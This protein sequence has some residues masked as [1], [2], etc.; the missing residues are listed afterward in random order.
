VDAG[1]KHESALVDFPE[2]RGAML[3]G[4][5]AHVGDGDAPYRIVASLSSP[6]ST[7]GTAPIHKRPLTSTSSRV[8]ILIMPQSTIAFKCDHELKEALQVFA[9]QQFNGNKSDAFRFILTQFFMSRQGH[10]PEVVAALS[11]YNNLVQELRSGISQLTA[12]TGAQLQQGINNLFAS[13][14]ASRR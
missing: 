11:L 1:Q 6:G 14:K 12:A 5:A 9:D 7:P 8:Y 4:A 10:G 2:R 13:V 3:H